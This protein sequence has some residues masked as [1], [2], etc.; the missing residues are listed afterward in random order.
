MRTL[1]LVL[2]AIFIFPICIH[3]QGGFTTVSGVIVDPNGIPWAGGTISAQLITQG[4]TTPTLN[5]QPFTATTTSGILGPTGNFTMRLG[6][7][8][9]IVPSTTTWQ[10]TISIAPG[11]LPPLGKGPQSFTVTTAINCGTNTPA[12]CTANAMTITAALVPV[13]ALSFVTGGGG[14][15]APPVGNNGDLQMKS[16]TLLAASHINDSGTTL[17]SNENAQFNFDSQ[18][19]GPNPVVDVRCYGARLINVFA[20]PFAAGVTATINSGSTTA[21][22]SSASTFVNGDGIVIY[23]AGTA[24]GMSTPAAPTVAFSTAAAPTGTGYV[25]TGAAGGATTTC[26]KIVARS[27]G[28]G[29]T[30]ASPET[31]VTGQALGQQ[32]VTIT[33]ATRSSNNL[34]TVVT[35]SAHTIPVGAMVRISL[36]TNDP[37]YGGW[38]IVN[39]VPD[40][41]HFTYLSLLDTRAGATSVAATGGNVRWWNC[42]HLTL[43]TPG[44]NVW[45]YAIYSG[46]SG[47]E[48]LLD[49]SMVAHADVSSDSSYMTWDDFGSSYTTLPALPGFWPTSPPSVAVANSL[50]TTIASGAGTT[51]LTLAASAGTSVTNASSRLDETPNILAALTAANSS[52]GM[53]YFPAGC[54][55]GNNSLLDVTA[56]SGTGISLNG[57]LSLWDTVITGGTWH[58]DLTPA[59]TVLDQFGLQQLI[60]L[61]VRA[62]KPGFVANNVAFYGIEFRPVGNGYNEI[63]VV[64]GNI[65]TIQMSN[66]GF[67]GTGGGDFTGTHYIQMGS[68]TAGTNPA[69]TYFHNITFNAAQQGATPQF[70]SKNF[71]ENNFDGIM[72]SG[73]GFFFSAGGSGGAS[74]FNM[75]YE[76]Q[77]LSTPLLTIRGVNGLIIKNIIEDTGVEPIVF[78]VGGPSTVIFENDNVGYPGS[79]GPMISGQPN[80][81]MWGHP[82]ASSTTNTGMNRNAVGFETGQVNDGTYGGGS[83]AQV[84]NAVNVHM[85]LGGGYSFY[86]S[87]TQPGQPTCATVTAGPPFTPAGSYSFSYFPVYQNGGWGFGSPVSNSCTADGATQQINVSLPSFF[88]GAKTYIWFYQGNNLPLINNSFCSIGGFA[89]LTWTLSNVGACGF[90]SLPGIPGGGPAGITNNIVW[91]INGQFNSVQSTGVPNVTGCSITNSIGGAS[92]GSFQSGTTGACTVTITPGI[93][94]I[95]GFACSAKDLTTPADEPK[96]TAYTTTTATLS[97]TTVSG[98]LIT[99]SCTGF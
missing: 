17:V 27:K 73:R 43:P 91:A 86:T 34:V 30:A 69:G 60:P 95:N 6:D 89:G 46:A 40:N 62:A 68:F 48:T 55:F 15:G 3:A 88:A 54:C 16:G 21:L 93:T 84:V 87:S 78:N 4:G 70:I 79:G 2:F 5:G 56:F 77:G 8:G 31:C 1:R 97:W 11:V 52:R 12:T 28:Q 72:G 22:L 41:T 18:F 53:I 23:G 82:P 59:F 92:A 71:G 25:V 24:N 45:Q 50:V 32:Q 74:S 33:S 13:P 80:L 64:P 57:I 29:I 61:D 76:I 38:F 51:T 85:L 9:V 42:N 63:F 67:A 19:C 36:T 96:Q 37:Q 94:A 26:Y 39:T 83:G 66:C 75:R 65:P 20:P 44:T 35:A 14:G 90:Q 49:V 58:G 7:N 47:A 99:W 81:T 98:D 10:F